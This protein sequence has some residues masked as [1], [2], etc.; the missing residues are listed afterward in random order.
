VPRSFLQC[1]LPTYV[2]YLGKNRLFFSHS[3][4][5]SK[6]ARN[7]TTV[8]ENVATP[9]QKRSQHSKTL[10]DLTSFGSLTSY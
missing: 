5:R 3:H 7:N 10:H 1:C 2:C 9:L 8:A 4:L 6:L